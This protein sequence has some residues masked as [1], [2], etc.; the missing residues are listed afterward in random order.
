[1]RREGRPHLHPDGA[2]GRRG[3]ECHVAASRDGRTGKEKDG[4]G[5]VFGGEEASTELAR[6]N[7]MFHGNHRKSPPRYQCD[8]RLVNVR[9]EV[10][11]E[12]H[13]A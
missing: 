3:R 10:H 9:V 11:V 12:S 13:E 6:I 2:T 4:G 5:E 8:K 7:E 1:M